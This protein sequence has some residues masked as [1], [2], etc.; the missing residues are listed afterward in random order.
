MEQMRICV[1]CRVSRNQSELIRLTVDHLSGRVVLNQSSSTS[2]HGR[3][4]YLCRSQSCLDKACK[5]TRLKVALSGRMQKNKNIRPA[6][7]WPLEPQ[8]IKDMAQLCTE[9]LKRCE[10]NLRKEARE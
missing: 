1:T 7:S 10:N 5:G 6:I 8:L 9:P 3:S 4:A 2:W